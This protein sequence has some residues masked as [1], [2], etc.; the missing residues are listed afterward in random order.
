MGKRPTLITTAGNPVADNQNAVTAGAQGPV[1]LQDYQLLEKLAHQNRER[2]PERTACTPKASCGTKA[3]VMRSVPVIVLILLVIAIP[4]KAG[5]PADLPAPPLAESL[6]AM[7]HHQPTNE[8]VLQREA[9]RYGR[10]QVEEQQRREKSEVD[11]LYDDVMRFSAP[12]A[13]DPALKPRS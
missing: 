9:E 10:Q 13:R 12:V 7:R 8:D 2:I 3:P 4:A 1:L 11:Q 5:M 6:D